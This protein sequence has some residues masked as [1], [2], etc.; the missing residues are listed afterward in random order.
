M[1]QK[2]SA[3][4]ALAG[5]AAMFPACFAADQHA[6]HKPLKVGIRADLLACGVPKQIVVRALYWYASRPAYQRAIIAGGPRYDLDGNAAGNVTDADVEHARNKLRVIEARMS[7]AQERKL[8]RERQAQTDRERVVAEEG[9]K[10]FD[11]RQAPRLRREGVFSG[12]P[13]SLDALR[14]AARMRQARGTGDQVQDTH[15]HQS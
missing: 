9:R 1:S 12:P 5:I 10:A 8:Q 4:E 2:Q 11:P 13:L 7:G 15:S 3:P 6:P 14:A